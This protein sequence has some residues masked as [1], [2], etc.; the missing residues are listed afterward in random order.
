MN[1]LTDIYRT[2][3]STM[4]GYAF[5]SGTNETFTKTNLLL[6]H[7]SNLNKFQNIAITELYSVANIKSLK[8]IIKQTLEHS[9]IFE[10]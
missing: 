5:F 8:I 7:W 2:S 10:N 3:L 1:D 4:A 9:Q 6:R